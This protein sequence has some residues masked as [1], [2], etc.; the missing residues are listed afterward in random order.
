[1]NTGSQNELSREVLIALRQITR[2]IDLH[3]TFLKNTLG[4]TGPQLVALGEIENQKGINPGE[5]ARRISLGMGTMTNVL[6]RLEEKGLILRARRKVDKRVIEL[7]LTEEGTTLL[8]EKPPL[9]QE[10]F[11]KRFSAL[12]NWEQ[13]QILSSLQ[14]ISEMMGVA[15][16][17]SAAVLVPGVLPTPVEEE[18]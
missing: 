10:S 18:D 11:L 12:A 2:A 16:M 15:E 6:D 9:L 13:H 5:L 17:D 7:E 8:R 3:S 1:M 14:R 4:I